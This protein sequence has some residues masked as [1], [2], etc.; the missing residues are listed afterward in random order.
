MTEEYICTR[1]GYGLYRYFTSLKIQGFLST[2]P[3]EK[4]VLPDGT[5]YSRPDEVE[6]WIIRIAEQIKSERMK[7]LMDK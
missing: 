6:D 2:D 3:N 5:F 1:I 7:I 4:Y